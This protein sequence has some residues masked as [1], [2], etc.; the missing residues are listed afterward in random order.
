[1]GR[2][3]ARRPVG[4]RAVG[5]RMLMRCGRPCMR[6]IPSRLAGKPPAASAKKA[7]C[8]SLGLV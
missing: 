2:R 7:H 6:F 5:Q 8:V 4:P 1:M 3:G